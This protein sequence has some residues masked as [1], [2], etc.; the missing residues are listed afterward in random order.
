MLEIVL[1]VVISKK[2]AAMLKEKGRSSAG[3]IVLFVLLWF[4]GEI[5]GAIVGTFVTM[6]GMAPGG[7]NDG[8][9][10]VA[11]IF[12]LFGAAIGGTVGYLIANAVPP[13]DDPRKKALD[14]F[15]DDLDED[16][17][18][19]ERGRERRRRRRDSGDGKFEETDR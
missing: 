15:D 8:F 2:I 18:D 19:R 1:I 6:A 10:F 7:M 3:Y 11:Y 5:V 16:D 4:G 9:N 14:V 12:A 17:D 13:L